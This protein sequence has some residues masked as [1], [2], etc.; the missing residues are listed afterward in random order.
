MTDAEKAALLLDRA[1]RKLCLPEVE[2][3]EAVRDDTATKD[4]LRTFAQVETE[5]A[6][7]LK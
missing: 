7:Y 5:F 1:S 3:L 4:Q 6:E 2:A